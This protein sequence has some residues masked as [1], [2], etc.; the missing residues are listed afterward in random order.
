MKLTIAS[1]SFSNG[2]WI[3]IPDG[4]DANQL[5]LLLNGQVWTSNNYSIIDGKI[6]LEG[7]FS[8]ATIQ[9]VQDAV[10]LSDINNKLNNLLNQRV[11]STYHQVVTVKQH[12]ISVTTSVNGSDH[13]LFCGMDNNTGKLIRGVEYLRQ[14]LYDAIFTRKHSQVLCRQRGSELLD[15]ID[16][17]MSAVTVP[18]WIA[19]I[20]EAI[21]SPFSGVPDFA[22][23]RVKIADATTGGQLQLQLWG[24]W[25]G[26]DVELAL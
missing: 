4:Y 10:D 26:S 16:S 6:F 22:L 11:L 18:L 21:S 1:T 15:N 19:D 2:T 25:L 20:V 5:M 9:L 7:D 3:D 13:R 23:T 12:S 8:H 17:P 14:R 24:K